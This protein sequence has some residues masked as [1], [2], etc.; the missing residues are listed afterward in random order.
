MAPQFV[1]R[2]QL[3]HERRELGHLLPGLR[4]Q[5]R[6]Q[7]VFHLLAHLRGHAV[8]HGLHLPKLLLQHL[9]EFVKGLGRVGAEGGAELVHKA[10]EVGFQTLQLVL[11]H[12]IELAQHLLHRRHL[13]RGHT[14][15]LVTHLLR[16]VLSHLA[17]EHVQKLLEFLLGFR[18]HEVVFHE[19]FDLP[20][21]PFW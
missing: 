18:V 10:L 1:H 19:F 4:V 11:H 8:H 6:H 21:D 3:L 7:R 17:F 15:D 12:L 16:H 13:V 9:H 14:L 5:G 2:H 20:A